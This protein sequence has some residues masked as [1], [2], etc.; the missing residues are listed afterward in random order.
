MVRTSFVN[1][2]GGASHSHGIWL[3]DCAGAAPWIVDN[4]FIAAAGDSQQTAVDGIRAMGDCHPVIDSNVHIAGGGEGQASSPNGVHCGQSSTLVSSQCVV[5]GNQLIRG[6]DFGFPPVATGVRCD[7]DGC[8]RIAGNFISGRGG[9]ESYGIWIEDASTMVDDN[10][11]LGGCSARSVGIHSQSS[12]ARV[13]NN[14]IG[15]FRAAD[16]T[17]AVANLQ[18]S[19]GLEA[20][21]EAGMNEIDVHSNLIDG[22]G[23]VAACVSS[24][25]ELGVTGTAPAHGVG[26]FRN[27]ILRGGQCTTAR[28][29]FREL[30]AA[31]DPRIVQHNDFDPALAPTALYFD[32]AATALTT[33]AAVNALTDTSTWGSIDFNPQ[34]VSYPTDLH[35]QA[36]S[37]CDG[38]GSAEGAP[39]LDMD[40]DVRDG[41]NPDIGP[42]EI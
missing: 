41:T 19:I 33:A 42:D 4:H 7:G 15:G 32:E 14:L 11:V 12:A 5:L 13:Q 2:W 22:T 36:G 10:F 37:P 16:C 25:V 1:A 30:V 17:G 34:F 24:A 38:A 27:N 40:G 18:A 35:L 8:M 9:V 6:S 26:I 39:T 23:L 31:A 29:G 3:E 20:L 21:V 28:Y